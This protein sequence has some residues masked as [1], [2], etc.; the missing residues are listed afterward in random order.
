MKN[1]D[2]EKY[3][4]KVEEEWEAHDTDPDEVIQQLGNKPIILK[5]P[6]EKTYK[7]NVKY[8][9]WGFV[10]YDRD[11][12]APYFPSSCTNELENKHLI[13]TYGYSNR[14]SRDVLSAF[15]RDC[16]WIASRPEKELNYVDYRGRHVYYELRIFDKKIIW[17][18]EKIMDSSLRATL[19]RKLSDAV[20][21]LC[22]ELEKDD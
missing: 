6:W 18:A 1:D 12:F 9:L 7:I 2:Q 8:C 19:F 5:V 10:D 13:R 22:R 4:E 14:I 11:Y 20:E 16:S 17:Q 3:E 15:I 21:K